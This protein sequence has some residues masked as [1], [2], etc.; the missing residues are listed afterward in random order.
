MKRLLPI[1][2]FSFLALAK[3]DDYYDYR[4]RE[5]IRVGEYFACTPQYLFAF[6]EDGEIN[7]KTRVDRMPR[8]IMD[9]PD[10]LCLAWDREVGIYNRKD[11]KLL[12]RKK[13]PEEIWALGKVK[14]H[15][16]MFFALTSDKTYLLNARYDAIMETGES[17]ENI[18]EKSLKVKGKVTVEFPEEI[19]IGLS[20]RYIF[21]FLPDGE[22]KWKI[23][24]EGYNIK[25][26]WDDY[27]ELWAPKKIKV[28][29][30]ST[31]ETVWEKRFPFPIKEYEG[32]T[33]R[34]IK[35]TSETGKIYTFD[36]ETGEI[37]E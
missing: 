1:L 22:I 10:Y 16:E 32:R 27:I 8:D 37:E 24:R 21:G 17:T 14:E 33:V 4:E 6:N 9:S 5:S 20:K 34:R 26:G 7:W 19:T 28:I 3:G 25:E 12:L 36:I 29:K 11:G 2:L 23:E 35:V 18:L 31:G 30:R 13:F 15:P